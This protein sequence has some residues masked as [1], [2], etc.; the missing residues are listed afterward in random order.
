[1][2]LSPADIVN[3]RTTAT[4]LIQ[5]RGWSVSTWG[6]PPSSGKAIRSPAL[7]ARRGRVTVSV[8]VPAASTPIADVLARQRQYDKAKVR[9]LWLLS[10]PDFPVTKDLPAAFI[11]RDPA[12]H[13]LA[14]LPG[15]SSPGVRRS[16]LREEDWLQTITLS[17]FL[18][19]AFGGMFWYG[20]VR[21]GRK[22]TVRLDGEFTKCADCGAWTNLCRAVEVLSTYPE[23][24]FAVYPLEAVPPG[25]LAELIPAG[26]EAAKV[27]PIRKRYIPGEKGSRIANSC[28]NCQAVQPPVEAGGQASTLNPVAQFDIDVSKRLAAVTALLSSARWRVSMPADSGT[29]VRL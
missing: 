16:A 22:A 19:A 23:S 29:G 6:G 20:T 14:R 17:A 25:L 12:G 5:G 7:C 3:L 21:E 15:R 9:C 2:P 11:D 18:E 1:M 4:S 26:L 10:T 27:G 8:E 24:S 13:Y 28:V